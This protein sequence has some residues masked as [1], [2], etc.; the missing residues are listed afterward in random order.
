MAF[1]TQSQLLEMGFKKLGSNVKISDKAS[2][3]NC[4]QIEIGDNSRIDDFC[5]VSGKVTI[6]RNVHLAVFNNVAG[7][8]LGVT[9]EDFSGLAYGCHVFSQSDDYSGKTLTNPTVPAEFKMEAKAPVKIGKHVIVGTS[10]IV[11]PGVE[12]AEGCS[13]GVMT[14]VNK[15]T[16]PWGVYF[17]IPAR[18]IKTRS[19]ELLA[20]EAKYLS[21]T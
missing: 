5:V 7:G 1:L 8:D 13:V 2:I 4:D 14:L 17:G 16:E 11:M 15:T 9:L 3:Y 10:S 6:G 19:Q 21:A 12:I 20:L 18:R